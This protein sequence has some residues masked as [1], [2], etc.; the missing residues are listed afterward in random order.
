MHDDNDIRIPMIPPTVAKVTVSILAEA[1]DY[2]HRIMNVPAMWKST[3]GKGVKLVVLDT[4]LP[5]HSDLQPC[6]GK[7]F[8]EGYL[9]DKNGHST[10]CAGIIAAHIINGNDFLVLQGQKDV[11]GEVGQIAI[12][13]IFWRG[14]NHQDIMF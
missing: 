1:T 4:G 13:A 6:G 10:H 12:D 5:K 9:E 2:N 7:S 14:G 8:I 11:L 3:M